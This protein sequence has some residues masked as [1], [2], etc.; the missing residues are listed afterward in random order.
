MP[1]KNRLMRAGQVEKAGAIARR[2]GKEITKR[3]RTRLQ[4]YNGRTDAKDMWA[5]VR[6]FTGV[7]SIRLFLMV[8]MQTA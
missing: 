8:L 3:N 4:K 6:Q 5:V 1:K 7:N 2:V